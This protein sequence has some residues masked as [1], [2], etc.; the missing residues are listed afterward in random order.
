MILAVHSGITWNLLPLVAALF[1]IGGVG[2]LLARILLV[3]N[4]PRTPDEN[5]KLSDSRR[6]AW[7]WSYLLGM[8]FIGLMLQFPLAMG[9][10]ISHGNFFGV[11]AICAA[12]TVLEC[13]LRWR[14]R[15][16]RQIQLG[17]VWQLA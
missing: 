10:Q 11:L 2:S 14:G 12:R 4:D 7:G 5:G 13:L 6:A 8:A 3:A 15:S 16:V 9:G 1:A 17:G